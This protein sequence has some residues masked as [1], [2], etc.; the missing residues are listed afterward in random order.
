[1]NLRG[2]LARI[3]AFEA[4]AHWHRQARANRVSGWSGS[5]TSSPSTLSL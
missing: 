5:F 4:A 2:R 3:L 1:M